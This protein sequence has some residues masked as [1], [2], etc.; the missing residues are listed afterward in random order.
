MTQPTTQHK[1][2]PARKDRCPLS[3][4]RT[5]QRYKKNH[6]KF[7]YKSPATHA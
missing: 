6:T 5:G 1:S 2:T 3:L 4:H 7:F